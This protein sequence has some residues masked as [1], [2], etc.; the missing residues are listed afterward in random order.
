MDAV[1]QETNFAQLGPKRV[2][3]VRDIYE[4][5]D[6]FIFVT[7]DRHSSFDR[8]IAHIPR[9]GEVLNRLSAWW[10]EQ[11]HHI[12]PNHAI[13]I[14]HGNLTSPIKSRPVA[15]ESVMRGYLTGVTGTSLWTHYQEGKR[16]FGNFRL[17]DGMQ[18]NQALTEPVFTPS[19]KED[20]HDKTVSPEEIVASGAVS[21]ELLT[22]IESVSRRLFAL[23]QTKARQQG[24][25]LVDTKYEFG[26]DDDGQLTLIDEI[27]TPDSSRYWQ[28][29]SYQARIAAGEEPDYF[30]KEFLRLWFIENSDPYHDDALPQAPA[31]LVAEL[32]RRYQDIFQQLTGTPLPPPSTTPLEETITEALQEH[33]AAH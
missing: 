31:E 14:P 15:V 27:H 9:K 8:L 13:S 16:D 21:A 17:P 1:L 29:G 20:E 11:T 23:G 2:G 19:T 12:V 10:F 3:K 4:D 18:K 33:V 6:R 30:D 28:A 7:T 22:E 26:L 32:S 5:G 25:I 24:L